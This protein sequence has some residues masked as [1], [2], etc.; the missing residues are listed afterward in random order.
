LI[1]TS[2][3]AFNMIFNKENINICKFLRT[4]LKTIYN[5]KTLNLISGKKAYNLTHNNYCETSCGHYFD[6]ENIEF[7][8]VKYTLHVNGKLQTIHNF[9]SELYDIYILCAV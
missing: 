9:I 2:C 8:E 4:E 1:E 3:I 7:V 6:C 5:Y